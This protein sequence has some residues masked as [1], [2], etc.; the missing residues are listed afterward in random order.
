MQY[1]PCLALSVAGHDR[2]RKDK[3]GSRDVVAMSTS[4]SLGPWV[5]F[6]FP[7]LLFYV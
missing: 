1:G 4:T 7:N 5:V 6:F 2:C 3:N